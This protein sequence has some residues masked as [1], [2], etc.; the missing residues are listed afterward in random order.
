MSQQT[1]CDQPL[2]EEETTTRRLRGT[3][4]YPYYYSKLNE[5]LKFIVP[6]NET[7]LVLGSANG[8]VLNELRPSR[9]VG[10][11]PRSEKVEQARQSYPDLEFIH[12]EYHEFEIEGPFEYIIL[13]DMAGDVFDLT[14]L[15]NRVAKLCSPTSRVII[16]QHNYLWRPIFYVAAALGLKEPETIQN[17]LSPGDISTMLYAAGMETVQVHSKLFMPINPFGLGSCV[18]WVMGLLPFAHRLGSTQLIVGRL[19]PQPLKSENELTCTICLTTRDEKENIEPLVRQIPELG[20]HTE[21][22]FVEGHSQDGT[23][24]EIERVLEAYPEKDI[25]LVDQP[26]VGQGDAIRVGFHEAKGDVIILLEADQTSPVEDVKKAWDVIGSGRADYVNGT[27][28]IYPHARGAMTLRNTI[29]NM[30]FALWFSWFLG[31]RTTDTLCGIK[32]IS[33]LQYE[34][35]YK[36]W[37]FLGVF[38]PFGDFEL[39]FGASKLGLKICETPTHYY[40]RQHGDTKTRFFAN[41]WML[42]K[43]ALAATHKFKCL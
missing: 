22:V 29:G 31:Q 28:F 8:D 24:E 21:I 14:E 41:G 9:G 11:D 23:R 13:N 25:R 7:V 36:T 12:S 33:K 27:R 43:M 39:I 26:G 42:A 1:L 17:W 6:K 34:K 3:R 38:D 16:H 10:L 40:P 37:G 19:L 15:L 20:K 32:G 2:V 18:N 4:R 30:F 5:Y 35:L